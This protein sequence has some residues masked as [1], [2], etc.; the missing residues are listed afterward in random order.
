MPGFVL[1]LF[2][3]MSDFEEG[4]VG[5]EILREAE[6]RARA[7]GDP[8][9]N[10]WAGG[11][12]LFL[13]VERKIAAAGGMS[14][15]KIFQQAVAGFEQPGY[16][17]RAILYGFYDFTRLQWTLV[18]ALLA[19]GILDEVYFPGIL[20]EDGS[21]SPAFAY[22]ALAWERLRAAFEGNVEYLEDPVSPAVDA[23]RERLFS[24]PPPAATGA[25]PFSVLSA[26][27]PPPPPPPPPAPGAPP[28]SPP[29]PPPKTAGGPP[30]PPRQ[31]REW[32]DAYPGE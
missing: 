28:P 22:A 20:R 14:R 2:R 10:R 18:D 21:L 15:R 6:A 19:S 3:T 27:P 13:A 29:P 32:R 31:V 5:E 25:V 17:F 12:R 8:K 30:P 1:A 26:P 24:P 16:P 4:W 7:G 11:G 9:A 23:V